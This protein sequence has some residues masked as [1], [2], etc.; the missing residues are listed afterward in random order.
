M[1]PYVTSEVPQPLAA[2]SDRHFSFFYPGLS[3]CVPADR[4]SSLLTTRTIISLT[5]L[6]P[7]SWFTNVSSVVLVSVYQWS[8]SHHLD[9]EC[10][11][12]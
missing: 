1:L 3:L 7:G 10:G 4:L 12:R 6:P 2:I 5:L 11:R 8:P 9:V